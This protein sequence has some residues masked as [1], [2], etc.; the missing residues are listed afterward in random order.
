MFQ[1]GESFSEMERRAPMT[2]RTL[3]LAVLLVSTTAIAA[4]KP[5]PPQDPAQTGGIQSCSPNSGP[6]LEAAL[7]AMDR[8]AA[9]FRSAQTDFVWT[10]HMALPV[11][12]TETQGG[13]M[14]IRKNGGKLQ[15][16]AD[17]SSPPGEGKYVLYTDNTV[18]LFEPKINRVTKYNAGKHKE[19]FES[20]LVLGFGGRGHDLAQRFEVRYCG[21]EKVQGIN[22]VRLDLTPKAADVRNT[23]N[24]I[25][26]WIDL[27]R[28]VSV[29]QKFFQPQ[30]G[31]YRLAVYKNIKLNQPL[32]HDAFS[33]RTDGKTTYITPGT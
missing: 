15:M 12:D 2:M 29:Q 33:L 17:I 28:G 26:L 1:P 13:V 3:L 11:E 5:A 19:A 16:A 31:D 8:A 23:F 32:P 22:T 7:N 4:P 21:T 24:R 20:F 14:Y 25:V 30:A 9:S 6:G 18:Q 27:E 10:T